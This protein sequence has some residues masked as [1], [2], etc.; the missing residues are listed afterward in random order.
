M[1][2]L[3]GR[4]KRRPLRKRGHENTTICDGAT[5]AA[6]TIDLFASTNQLTNHNDRGNQQLGVLITKHRRLVLRHRHHRQLHLRH[7]LRHPL[8]PAPPTPHKKTQDRKFTHGGTPNES[9]QQRQSR[10]LSQTTMH[11][12]GVQTCSRQ[13]NYQASQAKPSQANQATNQ[14]TNQP[15][16]LC[17]RSFERANK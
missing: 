2:T 16:S 14:P 15:F 9:Q 1:Q 3:L 6:T 4:R 10:V 8:S 7:H 12:R 13:P 17:S 5:K 11:A